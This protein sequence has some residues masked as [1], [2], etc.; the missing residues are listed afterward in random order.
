M[1]KAVVIG[2]G[3][4]GLTTAMLLAEAGMEVVVLDRD[5]P[6]P[7]QATEAWEGWERR[8]VAQ[9]HQV[10]V[11]QPGG[12]ALLETRLPGVLDAM[13]AA[14]V[15]QLNLAE[16]RARHLDL[17]G[18]ADLSPFMTRTTCRRP[19]LEF[20]FTSAARATPGVEIRNN[21][22]VA[23]LVTGAEAIAGVPHVVGVRTDSGEIVSGDVVIDAAGRRTPVP[24]LIEAAGGT[25]P[26]EH[27]VDLGF[28]YNSRYYRGET[29]PEYLEDVLSA[30]GSI[31][32]LTLPGDDG[33]WSVT[34]YHSS[35][36]K[37]MRRVRDPAVF[38]RVLRS[39]P[40]HAHWADGTVMSDVMTM[41]STANTTREFVVD[42]RPCATGLV[43]V[44]DAWGFTNPSI[45]RGVSLGVK[46]AVAFV[47]AALAVVDEPVEL[48]RRWDE[49]TRAVAAPWHASTVAFDEL[50]GPEVEALRQGLPDPFDES[51]P[52]VAMPRAFNSALHYDRQVFAWGQEIGGCQALPEEVFARPGAFE[53]VIEV[54]LAHP[55]YEVP[56]PNRAELETLLAG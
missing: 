15:P 5:D 41:V 7:A 20:G 47:D 19:V 52:S 25:R 36:D 56:G 18:E 24:G 23:E 14:G 44:G 42:G 53:R 48:A 11:L 21:S 54:A 1:A 13:V 17:A 12:R 8:S 27:A 22:A 50:R 37:D 10:H 16:L 33:Y 51:D 28:T 49:A 6:A 45:G 32:V 3:P 9:F 55:P 40:R 29:L 31:S 43:P 38:D 39:L 30:V 46:H 35:K 2:A 4:T 34:L 26:P